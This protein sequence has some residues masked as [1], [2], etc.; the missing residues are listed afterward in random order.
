MIKIAHGGKVLHEGAAWKPGV[1]ELVFEVDHAVPAPQPTLQALA[2]NWEPNRTLKLEAVPHPLPKGTLGTIGKP[3][4]VDGPDEFP[5][6]LLRLPYSPGL[7]QGIDPTTA[8]L[9]RWDKETKTLRPVW[10]SGVNVQLGF[11]WGKIRRSG[12]YVMIGLPSDKLLLD[13]LASMAYQRR[14]NDLDSP[15]E[16]AA[17]TRSAL[18]ALVEPPPEAVDQLR[19]LVVKLETNTSIAV[20]QKDVKRGRG[21]AVS[22]M[23]LPEDQSFTDLRERLKAL[24]TP[25]G[26]LPEENL[27]YPPE[28]PGADLPV[29]AAAEATF[30]NDLLKKIEALELWKWVDLHYWWPWLFSHDWW[31]YQANERHSGHAMGWSNIRSTN[32][33]RMIKLSPE[34]NL[35]GPV[36]TKPS[37]VDGKIY[38]GTSENGTTGGTLYKIDLFTGH[39]DGQYQTPT[40]PATYGIRG[41]GGSPAIV[42]ELAY[43]TSIHGRVYCVDTSTMTTGA[44]PPALWITD[45]KNPDPGQKQPLANT[46]ADSW[47]GP[48]VVNGNVYVGCG[49]GET[50]NACG[51]VYCLDAATGKVKWLFCTNQFQSGVDN[52]P[53]VVPGSLVP[54]GGLQPPGTPPPVFTE[55]ADPP[56]RG[57]SVWSSLAYC[58]ALNRVY[59]GTGNP[60]PDSFGPQALYSSGCI[61][62]D[63]TTGQLKGYWSPQPSEA[64]WP[65]D[66]DIDVP[67]G[68]MVYRDGGKW[69]VA[70]GSKS[71]AFVILDA[72]TMAVIARRQILPRRNGDGTPANPGTPLP[73]VVPTPP[74]G[75]AEN[76]YGVYGTPARAG[77]RLFVS[78][79]SDDGIPVIPDG[80]GDPHKTPFMRVMDDS[81][82]SDAWPTT[83]DAFGITR[84][85]NPNPPMYTSS[86][87]GVGSAA[88]V[89][90]VVFACTGDFGSPASIYAFDA[91]SGN[92]LWQDH[93]PVN[94]FCLGAA[95]YGNYVVIGAGASVRRYM[96]RPIFIPWPWPIYVPIPTVPSIGHGPRSIS[97]PVSVVGA[98]GPV[99]GGPVA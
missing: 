13:A 33:H 53:N 86:E 41:I 60:S 29:G 7:A 5:Q 11:M 44:P 6:T 57:A 25:P 69:C 67:G 65:G 16:R 37:I 36:Y 70:I 56:V 19:E 45:L 34:T 92:P 63:A 40:L 95:I 93:A 81:D 3:V 61:S 64:Y 1:R 27:F 42:D 96:L 12:V 99:M 38:V 83:T 35:A 28:I 97:I 26:G 79:G 59:V 4:K 14:C 78:M 22:G 73:S 20:P 62:L 49:E 74:P 43:F 10:N 2:D 87:S 31:M 46:E 85:A 47:S 90:D 52:Q 39:I 71:G 8:R 48:L 80:L 88:V 51:F 89:N 98:G 23:T 50:A 15:S 24:E 91:N 17:V 66:S 21:G 72:D 68:P 77:D 30:K 54:P 55:H 58:E 84:Y 18:A 76:H 32:A 94:S 75:G 82:L 9:F